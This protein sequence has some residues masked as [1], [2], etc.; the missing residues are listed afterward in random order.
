MVR[1]GEYLERAVVIPS[2]PPLEGLYH[3]GTQSPALLIA[4]PHPMAG[5]S[6]ETPLIAELAWAV[7]RAGHPTLRFNYRGVGASPGRF[8]EAFAY[9]DL[10]KAAQHLRACVDDAPIAVVGIGLGAN[11]AVRLA[12]EDAS[13]AKVLLI[14]PDPALDGD[15]VV[16]HQREHALRDLA[17]IVTEKLVAR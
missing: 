13:I 12:G 8:G 9:E 4:P 1:K 16:L 3:R 2:Q 7:T 5:G 11:L 10:L 6:M 17:R 14:D 15:R